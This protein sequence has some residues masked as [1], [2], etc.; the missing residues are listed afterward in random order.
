VCLDAKA[1][2]TAKETE[3]GRFEMHVDVSWKKLLF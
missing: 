1:L 2:S 3:K